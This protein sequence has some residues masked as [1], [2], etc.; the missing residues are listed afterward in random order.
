MRTIQL[1][2]W[3]AGCL[4]SLF[5]QPGVGNCQMLLNEV[6]A[7]PATDWNGSGAYSFRD[8]EWAEIANP[9][10]TLVSLDGYFLG[11]E[12]GAFVFGFTG[13][14]APGGVAVVFGSDAVVW[15]SSHGENATGLRLG[16]DG[17]TITL[18]RVAGPDT[19][20]VDAYTYNTVE[21]EDERSSGRVPDGGPVWEIFDGLNPYSGEG[22]PTGNGHN[23]TPGA[24][25][26]G[27]GP[28][29]AVESTWGR[30]KALYES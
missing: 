23:P 26:S 27:D 1:W 11:D 20:L 13:S 5:A 3:S 16:N 29:P 14:L 24:S 2:A 15:E 7:D 4:L 22:P 9:G 18:W 8:D 19:T 10:A 6:M 25:N 28:S 21:A 12:T 30:I 17:D